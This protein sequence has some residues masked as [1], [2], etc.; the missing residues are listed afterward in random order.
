MRQYRLMK[1]SLSYDRRRIIYSID[2]PLEWHSR[3][4]WTTRWNSVKITDDAAK[5]FNVQTVKHGRREKSIKISERY[6]KWRCN[7]IYR[8]DVESPSAINIS[9]KLLL[10]SKN[11]CSCKSLYILVKL[12]KTNYVYTFCKN[13]K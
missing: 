7:Y 9:V 3:R 12:H 10:F 6:Q 8:Q 13:G 5:I 11:H 1:L 2:Y 4:V